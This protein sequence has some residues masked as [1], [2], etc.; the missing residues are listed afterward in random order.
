MITGVLVPAAVLGVLI[1]V[2]VLFFQR[3]REGVD[4][5]PRALL[6][7][8][9]YIASLAGIVLLV[10][11]LASVTNFALASALGDEF[12]YGG[13][14]GPVPV[15]PCPPGAIDCPDISEE[16]QARIVEQQRLEQERRR[17]EDL[18]R[19]LTFSVFGAVF[20]GA[21]W[22]ARRGLV[23]PE[24]RGSVLWRGYLML[25]T[26]VFGLATVV[27]LPTGLYQ[28]LANV[29][30]SSPDPYYYRP[31]ADALGGGLVSLPVWLVY[32]RLAVGEFRGA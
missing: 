8:Y 24:E 4:L 26:V 2:A 11:G 30:L 7:L 12:V 28:A 18:I 14:V 19:G 9:L 21:H 31:G 22:M 29:L 3:G 1:L 17:S 32:L 23:G 13:S 5:S 25:G 15:R 27:L 10:I 20:W 16:E 6:R